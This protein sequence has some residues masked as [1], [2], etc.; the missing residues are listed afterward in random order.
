MS[1]KIGIGLA[2]LRGIPLFRG[3]S[4]QEVQRLAELFEPVGANEGEL[5]FDA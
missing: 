3:F 4:D 2:D 5:L 1:E